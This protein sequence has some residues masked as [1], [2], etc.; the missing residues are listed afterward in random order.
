MFACLMSRTVSVKEQCF[1]LIIN[2]RIVLSAMAFQRSEQ[3]LILA[4]EVSDLSLFPNSSGEGVNFFFPFVYRRKTV[5]H[6]TPPGCK[7]S[8]FSLPVSSQTAFE[9][10]K[11]N[12]QCVNIGFNK[13]KYF[14]SA[15]YLVEREKAGGFIF[16]YL[17]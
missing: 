6:C 11:I 3:N 7:T 4:I 9:P 2:Q 13:L 14:H 12:K 17:L 16:I 15:E 1:S 5:R 8:I 10:D